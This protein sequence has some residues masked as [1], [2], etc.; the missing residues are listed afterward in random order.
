MTLFRHLTA[1]HVSVLYNVISFVKLQVVDLGIA[2]QF[3]DLFITVVQGHYNLPLYWLMAVINGRYLSLPPEALLSSQTPFRNHQQDNYAGLFG[4]IRRQ[5]VL[6]LPCVMIGV[7]DCHRDENYLVQ[8][9]L[10]LGIL[11]K[12]LCDPIRI[13]REDLK[14]WKYFCFKFGELFSTG[15]HVDISTKL[16]QVMRN[17]QDQVLNLG[18]VIRGYS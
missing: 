5:T 8:R 14:Q 18:P 11:N 7:S 9:A 13:T 2:R 12:F 10:Q 6:F 15:F 17:V 16:H 1:S 3:C 4:K